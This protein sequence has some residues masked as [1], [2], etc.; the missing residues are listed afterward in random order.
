VLAWLNKPVNSIIL[1]G[2]SLGTF[3]VVVNAAKYNIKAVILQCPIGS[4]ACMFYEEYESNIKFKEDHFA[5]IEHIAK[6]QGR[7]LMMHSMADEVIPIGQAKLL[8]QKY[9]SVNGIRQIIF[10]EVEKLL[11][12]NLHKYITS[13]KINDLQM[14]VISFL[15]TNQ[16]EM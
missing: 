11:H 8:L 13:A 9:T 14:E 2:F 3:P 7:V 16:R 4:L 10:I 5:N 1:W 15:Q 12:N 6:V